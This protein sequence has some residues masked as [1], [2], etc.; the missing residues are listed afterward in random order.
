M[1]HKGITWGLTLLVMAG[2]LVGLWQLLQAGSQQQG[3]GAGPKKAA[4]VEVVRVAQSDVPLLITASGQV[5]ALQTLEVRPQVSGVVAR[6]LLREGQPVKAGQL[7]FQLEDG[8]ERAALAQARAQLQKN[9]AQLEDAR[10]TLASNE[11]LQAQGFIAPLAVDS[12]RSAV[13][14]L[15][16]TLQAD[17]AAIRAAENALGYKT[18]HAA[19]SG[20]AGMINVYPGSVVSLSMATP[21]VTITQ[22]DPIA[23]SFTVAERDLPRILAVQ[24]AGAVAVQAVLP[25]Q[26]ERVF[27]GRLSFIDNS[28][29]AGSGTL[30]LKAEFPN[31]D[32]AL[33]PGLFVNL[34]LQAGVEK[35]VIVLPLAGLQTGPEGRFVYRVIAGKVEAQTVEVLDIRNDQVLVRGPT[36]GDAVVVRGGLNLRPGDSVTVAGARGASG[37][38]QGGKAGPGAGKKAGDRPS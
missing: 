2:L 14:S 16:A 1:K 29:D 26:P 9:R 35:Q 34:S 25:T 3:R 33:W 24:R 18:L 4:T 13:E 19:I 17:Q 37:K 8:A 23:V 38:G 11:K 7:L 32:S 15:Q 10:R 6:V 27:E 36:P 21:M 5:S 12:S 31:P 28:V 30:R 20:R 22:V